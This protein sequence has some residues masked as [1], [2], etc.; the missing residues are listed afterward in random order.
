MS[1][2][3]LLGSEYGFPVGLSGEYEDYEGWLSYWVAGYK[4]FGK[5]PV[6]EQNVAV[7]Y[8]EDVE[9]CAID[10]SVEFKSAICV[11]KTSL[12]QDRW[13]KDK[14]PDF[15]VMNGIIYRPDRGVENESTN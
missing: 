15:I 14:P 7:P 12:N 13:D 6:K 8:Q 1:K 3:I 5:D 9:L 4:P 11:Q 2:Y 10:L